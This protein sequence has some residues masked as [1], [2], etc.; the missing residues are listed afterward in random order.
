LIYSWTPRQFKNFVKG[1]KFRTVDEYEHAAVSAMFIAKASNSRKR[2]KLKDIYDADK[3]RKK[4]ENPE[5]KKN[6]VV[7]F[8]RYKKA[9]EAMRNYSPGMT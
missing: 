6:D 2:L 3:I 5:V 8:E 4:I 1:A 7:S 9:K